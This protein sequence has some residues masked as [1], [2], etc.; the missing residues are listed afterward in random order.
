MPANFNISWTAG[1]TSN[2]TAQRVYYRQKSIGGAY[3]TT[4]F[5]PPNDLPI[6]A[7]STTINNLSFNR[8]YEFLVANICSES[9]QPIYSA[10][11]E[12]INFECLGVYDIQSE[13][14]SIIFYAIINTAN[15]DINKVKLS[16]SGFPDKTFDVVNGSNPLI[17]DGLTPDTAYVLQVRYGAIVNGVQ[18]Y[19]T[20]PTC[21]YEQTT[22]I[23][24]LAPTN[25][26][27][28]NTDMPNL[29]VTWTPAVGVSAQRVFARAKGSPTWDANNFNLPN[30][31]TGLATSARYQNA[32]PNAVTQFKVNSICGGLS[33]DSEIAES[34]AFDCYT[35]VPSAI[36][37][38]GF[39]VTVSGISNDVSV[40]KFKRYA[41]DGTTLL[42]T[43]EVAVTSG[44]ATFTYTG[45]PNDTLFKINT[46]IT[47]PVTNDGVVSNLV[48]PNE[49]ACLQDVTTLPDLSD[50]NLYVTND[51]TSGSI[52]N[53]TG[54]I[55]SINT[56]AF[57]ID[58][59]D[60]LLADHTGFA[61]A[62][63]VN[64]TVPD[65]NRAVRWIK[66]NIVQDTIPVS[67][68]GS[69]VVNIPDVDF[70]TGDFIEITLID[71]A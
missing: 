11:V 67:G 8:V 43:D 27:V 12:K 4:G 21:Q 53:V 34:V 35:I 24:C 65:I 56:G 55:Y 44:V 38:T 3:I 47:I 14:Y 68:T 18:I 29:E 49:T 6:N 23:A 46:E 62:I 9:E 33:P 61:G 30:D 70:V 22:N 10:K 25:I 13:T 19:D 71:L 37:E 69:S 5:I 63:N 16:I 64:V 7:T 60:E 54:F 58:P 17:F 50:G 41:A 59:A 52:T 15:V 48:S 26:N 45:L 51:A 31:Q 40:F 1:V 42:S 66:N 28:I 20:N 57:P 2:T 32:L 39:T 36:T